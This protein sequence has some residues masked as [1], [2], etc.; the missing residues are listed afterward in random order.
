MTHL[1]T[2]AHALPLLEGLDA[3]YANQEQQDRI[4]QH[5]GGLLKVINRE[6]KRYTAKLPRLKEALEQALDIEKWQT[7]GDLLYAYGLDLPSGH[8]FLEVS[9][10]SGQP[11]TIPLD[12]RYGGKENA[13]RY[14]V[15]YHKGKTGQHYIREQIELTEQEL[16]YFEGLRSQCEQA[17]IEDAKEIAEELASRKLFRTA[18]K[19]LKSKQKKR[20][21][22]LIL[23]YDENT[24]VLIGKNNV[25]NDTLTFKVAHKTDYWFHAA[26]TFGAHVILKS[27]V[28]N[29]A[30]IR[31]CANCAAYYSSSRYSSSVPVHYTQAKNIKKIP[32]KQLGFV[33]IKEYKT[34]YID[35]D[36]STIEPYLR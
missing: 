11:L 14:Y 33:S 17:D 28:L 3:F 34:I 13:R 6:I 30:L 16:Q 35:P 9:D 21:N 1:E 8:S 22:Y 20:P 26:D 7:Y 36:F 10:F 15:K 24:Q 18:K 31:F 27:A 25:Q 4:A 29:E 12:Q 5:T 19:P 2:P 23:N 32:Q